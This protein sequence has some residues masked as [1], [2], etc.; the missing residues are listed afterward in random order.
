MTLA[1]VYNIMAT[2]FD[3]EGQIDV[4]SLQRLVDFQIGAGA[5][6]L[7]ILG[8]MGEAHKLVDEERLLVTRTV[9]DQV[10]GRVPVVVGAS[11]GGPDA[12]LWLGRQA[13]AIG[14]AGVMCAPPQ[15]L[16]NLDAV[17]EYYRRLAAGLTI[18]VVVQDEPVQTGV[19][20]P[21]AFLGRL[22]NEIEGC[23]AIKL[24]D[25]PTPQKVTQ[26]L[27]QLQRPAP[28]FGGLGGAQFYYELQRGAA[29]TMT[30]FAFTE[31]LVS[32][33]QQHRN[34]NVAGA[35]ATHYRNLPLIAYEAQPQVGLALRKEILRRRGAIASA[36]VRQ[37]AMRPDAAALAELDE[38]LAQLGLTEGLP[39]QI[40]SRA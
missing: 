34:G 38:I 17:Y 36:A 24:E 37:P 39:S 8:I 40:P 26:V 4:D 2:P 30:G 18:P 28:V 7:T 31:I 13:Q 12:A 33:Y 23:A 14:A 21:A 15:N 11:A 5:D 6:G 16:R 20:M 19:Q 22:C 27:A 1:G 10:D 32:I 9:M 3:E 35:R 29:G 25:A